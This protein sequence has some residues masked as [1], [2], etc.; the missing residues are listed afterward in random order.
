VKTRVV[1]FFYRKAA[2]FVFKIE[3]EVQ[4][5]DES[6]GEPWSYWTD[7]PYVASDPAVFDTQAEAEGIAKRLS[8]GEPVYSNDLVVATYG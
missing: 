5:K 2:R 3:H 6:T 7:W 4:C 1:K 8:A